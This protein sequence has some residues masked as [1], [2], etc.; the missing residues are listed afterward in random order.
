MDARAASAER[1]RT[2][3]WKDPKESAGLVPT[4]PGL[5]FLRKI[6]DGE[7][8]NPPIADALDYELT[9]VEPGFVVFEIEPKEFHY[10]P[11]GTVHGGVALTLMDSAMSCAVQTTLPAGTGYTTLEVKLN[12][13]RGVSAKTG[14]MR[15]EGKIIHA[16]ARTAIA[17]GRFVDKDGKLYAHATTTCFI[18]QPEKK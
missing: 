5:E 3:S 6:R 8:P 16:G 7:I 9:V 13:V 12:F 11:I 18:M 17:E 2:F 14:R 4:M 15:A 10:N 1:T